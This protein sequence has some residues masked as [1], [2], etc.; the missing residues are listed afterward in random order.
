MD[1][2][3]VAIKGENN[4][5]FLCHFLL[6]NVFECLNIL[7]DTSRFPEA[8]FFARTYAP[9]HVPRLVALW[10]VGDFIIMVGFPCQGR[11]A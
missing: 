9:S 10:K 5:T 7:T 2:H 4:I 6:G 3:R 8:A 1:I 11:K